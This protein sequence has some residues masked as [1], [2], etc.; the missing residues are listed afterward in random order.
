MRKEKEIW[1]AAGCFWG[2]QKFFKLVEGVVNT[3]VGFVNGKTENPTYEQVYQDNT[4][5]AEC[6]HVVYDPSKVSLSRLAGLFFRIIDPLSLNKQGED[7]GTRYRTGVYY[8]EEEDLEVLTGVFKKVKSD[9]GVEVFPVELEP[10]LIFYTADEYHQDY[11]DK[12]PGGYCHLSPEI[13]KL[14]KE[15]KGE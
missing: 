14:A 15:L 2:A 13:F 6:V 8:K 1:F 12:N 3:E 10:V 9:L 7:E 5:Y 11:L 4:G